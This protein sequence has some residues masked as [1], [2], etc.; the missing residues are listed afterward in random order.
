MLP[1]GADVREVLLDEVESVDSATVLE[2]EAELALELELELEVEPVLALALE[3]GEAPE[4]EPVEPPNEPEEPGAY[5]IYF[6]S[7]GDPK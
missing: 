2:E 6:W 4:E 7:A 3:L 1:L 5:F